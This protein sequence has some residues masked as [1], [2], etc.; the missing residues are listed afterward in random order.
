[1]EESCY[2]RRAKLCA[3][4]CALTFLLGFAVSA[5]AQRRFSQTYPA[6]R[7]VHLR[8]INRTGTIEVVAVPRDA[9]RVIAF[10]ESNAARCAPVVTEDGI[11]IDMV[12]DNFDREDVGDINFRIE[13]P[14]SSS[15]D[16][17]TKRGNI[18]V[19]GVQ[20]SLVRARVSTEGD[21]EL[22]GIR[23]GTVIASNTSG[24][25]F[26]DGDLM[27]EGKYELT[28]MAGDINVR[29]PANSG[30]RLIA[31]AREGRN[32]NLGVFGSMGAFDFI[33]DKNKRVVGRVGDGAASLMMTNHRGS[34][35]FHR[36]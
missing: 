20:G 28:S 9:V 35:L 13:V 8:L 19:R 6:R 23:A 11:E 27:R 7:N 32:I 5:S 16:L 1:M 24:N 30:F 25:I 34:I 21:I 26:F 31:V 36:R 10:M 33:G 17:E 22:T 18:T 29:I 15:V 12:R 14:A 2:K 3:A 4:A